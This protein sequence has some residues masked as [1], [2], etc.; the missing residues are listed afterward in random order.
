MVFGKMTDAP[1][2][3]AYIW[4]VVLCLIVLIFLMGAID[5]ATIRTIGTKDVSCYDRNDNKIIDV[6]CQE[7][8]TCSWL[9]LAGTE[10]R[11]KNWRANTNGKI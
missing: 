10:G 6:T 5:T 9:G 7:N 4:L 3:F 8:I 11:C 2:V 1:E